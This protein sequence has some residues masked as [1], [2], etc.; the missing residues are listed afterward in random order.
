MSRS[1]F[2][3]KEEE[4]RKKERKKERR[5]R[6]KRSAG[7][8]GNDA[9]VFLVCIMHA[10]GLL[11]GG[12]GGGRGA[13]SRVAAALDEDAQ[14]RASREILER[15]APQERCGGAAPRLWFRLSGRAFVMHAFI[16]ITHRHSS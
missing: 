2:F 8:E 11:P 7:E 14:K 3:F 16:V 5:R 9:H 13:S 1:I 4:E 6:L 15:Q 12:G 10:T